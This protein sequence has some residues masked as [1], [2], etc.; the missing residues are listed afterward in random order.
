MHDHLNN[1]ILN[2]KIFSTAKGNILVILRHTQLF[3]TS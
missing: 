3:F 2:Q 1:K